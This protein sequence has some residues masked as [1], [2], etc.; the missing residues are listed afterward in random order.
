MNIASYVWIMQRPLQPPVGNINQYAHRLIPERAI[1]C[2]EEG[3]DQYINLSLLNNRLGH[4]VMCTL[5]APDEH[6]VWADAR[7]QMEPEANY[8]TCEIATIRAT[9]RNKHRHTP[10]GHKGQMVF[11]DI[12]PCK[13]SWGT[14]PKSSFAYDLLLVDCFRGSLLSMVS[15]INQPKVW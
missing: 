8:T 5:L 15:L 13:S 4:R 1:I 9:S 6:Q 12:I 10:T 11:I 7:I 3:N 2:R 14:T